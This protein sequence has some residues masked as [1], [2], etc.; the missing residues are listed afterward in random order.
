M[1]TKTF[2]AAMQIKAD[3]QPGEF[4]AVFSTF[5]VVDHDGDVTLPGAFKENAAVRISYWGHRWQDLPVGRGTIHQNDKQA[6]V[7][8]QFFLDTQA[9][10]ETYLTVKNLGELQ[11]WSYGYDILQ[12]EQGKFGKDEEDVR[13]LKELE[14]AEVSPVMLGAGIDTHT[15][16]IKGMKAAL[17][18]H[19]TATTDAAWDG[20]AMDARCPSERSPL[21]ATHAWVD[22]EGDPDVKSSYRFIHHMVAGDGT[23]GAAN[24][25][26]CQTGIGVLNGG[27]GGTTIPDSDRRG[28]WNHLAKHL[29]DADVEPPELKGGGTPPVQ[30][31]ADDEGQTRGGSEADS[32]PS[33]PTPSVIASRI[34]IEFIE[35]A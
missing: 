18:S 15:E 26:G 24:I 21:R 11:E 5:N 3:G 2:R 12:S 16:T 27:R 20:P 14:V 30:Q 17:P 8:G 1:K 10:K 25:R 19:S 9:G 31:S 35:G 32:E 33:N 13:F 4:R 6:W 29:R 34:E 23:P 28:V 22:P 7:D